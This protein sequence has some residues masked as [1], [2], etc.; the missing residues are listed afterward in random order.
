MVDAHE[1]SSVEE[2][3][4]EDIEYLRSSVLEVPL[5]SQREQDLIKSYREKK[6]K[7]IEKTIELF[8]FDKEDIEEFKKNVVSGPIGSRRES[9]LILK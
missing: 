8:E 7:D 6:K 4:Q 2:F 5:G 1:S 9:E 3:D